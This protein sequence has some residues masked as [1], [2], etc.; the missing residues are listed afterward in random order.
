MSAPT[1]RHP[2]SGRDAGWL[3]GADLLAVGLAFLGQI[4]LVNALMAEHYGWMVLAIDLYASLFLVV[5]LGLPTLLARDGANAPH[6]VRPAVARTYRLQALAAVPFMLLALTFRPDRWLNMDAPEWLLVAAGL[7]A[8]AHIASYAPRSALR[9]LGEARLE[10]VSKVVERGVTVAGYGVLVGVGSTSVTAYMGAFLLGACAGWLLALVLMLR[11]APAPQ[12]PV[13]LKAL[14]KDWASTKH[15]LVAALPFAITLGA[16]PYVVRLEKFLTAASGG[17]EIAAVFHVAQ[18]AWLA[19]LVVPAAL[20]SALLPVLGHVRGQPVNFQRELDRALD[21]C[22][23]LM[24]YGLF[25]GYVLVAVLAPFAFPAPYLDGTYGASAVDLFTVL[26]VG[27]AATLLA[28]PTYTSLIAGFHPWRF[29]Q[30]IFTVLLLAALIG[31]GLIF[32]MATTS[33]ATLYAAALASSLSAVALLVLSWWMSGQSAFVVQRRDEWWLTVLGGS[34]IVIGLF[35]QTAWW[36][37]GLPLFAFTPQ[38]WRA[39]RSTNR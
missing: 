27:W 9:A 28:T 7:T 1:A 22:F 13:S 19:G 8:V 38:A 5:D 31:Y 17:A 25:G 24:P 10:A 39:L 37:L 23:G 36:V 34:F 21:M 12:T 35:T 11:S 30:F 20:R 16:L 26:L 32:R 29:T 3:M 15:L 4:L 2:S 33:G 18:L 14:G 6:L